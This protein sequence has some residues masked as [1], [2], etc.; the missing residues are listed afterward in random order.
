MPL[1]LFSS[2]FWFAWTV[3]LMPMLRAGVPYVAML[4][5]AEGYLRVCG[6]NWGHDVENPMGQKEW[7]K[8][9]QGQAHALTKSK[10]RM[11]GFNF[12]QGTQ[13]HMGIV[14]LTII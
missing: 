10:V 1:Q 11:V 8:R 3:Y 2:E 13:N 12:S 4:P 14:S 7:F 5:F 6:S 9:F